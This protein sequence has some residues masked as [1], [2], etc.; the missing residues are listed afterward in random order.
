MTALLTEG[1][2][3]T[4]ARRIRFIVV[5]TIAYNVIEAVIALLAGSAASSSALIAFGLDST[6]EV[7]SALAV[8]WQFTGTDH[9]RREKR[10]L[11]VIAVSFWG[12]ALFVSYDAVTGLMRQEPAD[13]STIGIVLAAVSLLIMPAMSYLERRTGRELGS[14]SAVADSKQMLLCTYMSA[15]LLVGLLVNSLWSWWWADPLAALVI[16]ALALREGVSAWRGEACC[17]PA[18][19]LF[20]A[21]DGGGAVCDA[22]CDCC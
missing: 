11:R 22:R 15:A 8:A 3:A 12:L 18:G 10:A 6:V 9:E 5:V 21:K 4:L 1:R 17:P 19:G 13:P 7:S 14:Q 2:R 20:A 16:A